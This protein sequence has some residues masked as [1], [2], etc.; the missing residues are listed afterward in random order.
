M[1]LNGKIFFIL[2][3]LFFLITSVVA[4]AANYVGAQT[5]RTCHASEY[6]AWQGSHHALAMQHAN[7]KSVLGD[8]NKAQFQYNG[9]TTTFFK[10]GGKFFVNTDGTDG[11][12]QD[13]EI[14]YTFGVYP[15]QQYLVALPAGRFQALSVAWDARPKEAGGQKWFHLYPKEKI[16]FKDELHWT[17]ISQNWNYMCA[18]CHTTN[19]KK[20]YDLTTNKFRTTWSEINVSCESCHGPASQHLDWANKTAGSEK[21]T[22]KGLAIQLNE[23]KGVHWNFNETS[24]IAVR[25]E[26]GNTNKEI[27]TCARCHSR[28]TTLTEEYQHGKPLMDSHLPALITEP[29]YH[30]D[31]QIKEEDFEY[32][33]FIQ[34]KMFH[35]GVT[36]SDCHDPHSQKLRAPA[37]KTCLQ[38]HKADK[39]DSEKHHFHPMKSKGALC[40]DC[41]MPTTNFMVI[42]ARHDHSIRIPRPDWTIKMGVPNACNQCHSDKPASWAE[43]QLQKWYGKDWSPG[44]DFGETLFE[45]RQGL[46]QAGQDLA[47]VA[48]SPKIADIARATAASELANYLGPMTG[49]VL[50][51]LLKDKSPMVRHAALAVVDQVP[52]EHRWE[53]AGKLLSDSVLSVRIEAVRV[54]SVIPRQS[55]TS[56]QQQLIDSVAQE[57]IRVQQ[58]SAELPQSHVNL[59]LF[60]LGLEQRDKAEQSY[61]QALKLDSSYVGA[62][63]NLAD[64][65][66]M[67]QQDDKAEAT[68]L[69]ARAAIGE[70]ADVE[71][72]LGLQH[73]RQGFIPKALESLRKA[74][75]L[76]PD[77]ARFAYVYAVALHDSG[78]P[79]HAIKVLEEVHTKHPYDRDSLIALVSFYHAKGE[80]QTASK[81]AQKLVDMDPSFGSVDEILKYLSTP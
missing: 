16:D 23:R 8:F 55:L 51:Q 9:I 28:R 57:Y 62:Y 32:G 49:A 22:D 47:A 13:Y 59:G 4:H 79:E 73:V 29:L 31:G 72:A 14:Q 80:L 37:N 12:L 77:D 52:V 1:K 58:T 5:C 20:N 60:Y 15:L 76:R 74:T 67:Q 53:L 71:H 78:D 70:N 66:R 3:S 69:E 25:S 48:M 33:S 43:S 35:K 18:E 65:Y 21:I 11:K 24:S 44:W 38:C 42:H 81:Y 40:A 54:L 56:S 2:V 75:E 41:H 36:C 63:I 61:Q 19:L 27:E 46:P 45:V 34:S 68:L 26:P 64:L 7:D 6:T 30:A 10:Q 39:Y 17:K 50:P